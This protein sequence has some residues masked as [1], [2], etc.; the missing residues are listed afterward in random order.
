M[1]LKP[2]N[3]QVVVLLGASSGIGRAT[4]LRFAEGGAK[5]VVAARGDE[6]LDS[7]LEAIRQI[8]GAAAVAVECD[9]SDYDQVQAVADRAVSEFGHLDTWVHLAAIQVWATFEETTPQEFRRIIDVN[10]TGQAYGAMAALPYMRREGRGALIHVSSVLARRSVPY[11]SAYCA[12]KRGI[13]GFVDALRLE[14]KHEGVPISVTNVLPAAINTPFYSTNRTRL[15]VKPFGLAP[16]YDPRIVADAIVYAAEHPQ[17]E[18]VVGGVGQALLLGQRLS[19]V[20][21][22]ALVGAVGFEAQK[23]D[24]PK[25]S[26]APSA[27][28][29]PLPDERIDGDFGRFTRR[30]SL[31]TWFERNPL[32]SLAAAG[33]VAGVAALLS[34]AQRS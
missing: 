11:Q 26:D 1:Q 17:R 20:L 12:S 9:T 29:G 15:G 25:L 18:V 8:G 32:A 3:E 14:L 5:L 30:T 31:Y 24:E 13:D 34:R 10:L 22:D 21:M 27:I 7:L 2:I 6:K 4:A 23:T 33:A 19:P 28:D 16:L